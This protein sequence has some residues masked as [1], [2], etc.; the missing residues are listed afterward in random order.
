MKNNNLIPDKDFL[1]LLGNNIKN[2]RKKA[3]LSQEGLALKC[4]IDRAY[5]G[6]VE[7]G[8]MNISILKLKKISDVLEIRP[9]ELL[10]I[11]GK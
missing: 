10:K 11:N 5:M 9:F 6:R 4:E 3:D 7:R 8:E 1:K 2:F